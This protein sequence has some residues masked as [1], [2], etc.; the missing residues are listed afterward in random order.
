MSIAKN[1]KQ[2]RESRRLTQEDLANKAGISKNAIYNYENERSEPNIKTINKIAQ[3][4]EVPS[5]E[6]LMDDYYI[7]YHIK[8]PVTDEYKV[9]KIKKKHQTNKDTESNLLIDIHKQS[10][11]DSITKNLESLDLESL[12]IID[13]LIVKLKNN[14]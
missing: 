7:T 4:L 13:A 11:K 3:A 10:Y 14:K 1:I 5:E 9:V 2:I 8:D 12:E 6:I